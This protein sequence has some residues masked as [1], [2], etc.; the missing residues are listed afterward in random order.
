MRKKIEI[1]KI[2]NYLC[3]LNTTLLPSTL[4]MNRLLL[5][6]DQA[7]SF[8]VCLTAIES[9]EPREFERK[10]KAKRRLC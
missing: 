7:R 4:S 3:P 2:S 5:N 10:W 9:T 6:L 8:S 1:L